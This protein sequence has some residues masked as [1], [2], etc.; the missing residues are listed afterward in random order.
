[1]YTVNVQKYRFRSIYRKNMNSFRHS[2][3]LPDRFIISLQKPK[4]DDFI[5]N[6]PCL[7]S[8]YSYKIT[9]LFKVCVTPAEKSSS[10]E[11]Y[12]RFFSL[13]RQ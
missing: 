10:N 7:T 11:F 5:K 3:V 8:P 4:Y 2:V 12:V 13:K 1:M 6:G 9:Y